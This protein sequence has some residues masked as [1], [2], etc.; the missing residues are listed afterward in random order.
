MNP[1]PFE[2]L[3]LTQ[4][5]R[6][7]FGRIRTLEQIKA[8]DPVVFEKLCGW[9]Y[10][11]EGYAVSMTPKTGDQGVDLLLEK[12]GER[13]VVQC[14]RYDGTVGQ[15]VVRDLFGTMMHEQGTGAVLITSGNFSQQA[16]DWG[17]EKPIRLIDGTG[18]HNWLKY[19]N[20]QQAK[21]ATKGSFLESY[22]LSRLGVAGVVLLSLGLCLASGF[23]FYRT[24]QTIF[25]PQTTA[26]STLPAS[27]VVAVKTK[28]AEL[29]ETA[30]I[31]VTQTPT[32]T[33]TPTPTITALAN[34]GTFTIAKGRYDFTAD[35][36]EWESVTPITSNEQIEKSEEWGGPA[37]LSAMWRLLYDENFLYGYVVVEDDDLTQENANPIYLYN[38]DSLELHIDSLKDRATTPQTDDFQYL[39]SPG[40]F[41][42]VKAAVF[43][44]EGDGQ[45]MIEAWGTKAEIA[46]FPTTKGYTISFRIPWY[47]L[48]L[49]RPGLGEEIGISL[50]VNDKDGDLPEQQFTNTT[51]HK[52]SQPATWGTMKLGE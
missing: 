21:T 52:W 39:L 38:G 7:Q 11:T 31:G 50:V 23:M 27:T 6:Q 13:I 20:Q 51:T 43:R 14:K 24:Y 16:L 2:R 45:K 8:L 15:P 4:K 26:K 28:S 3:Q 22:N 12:K 29:A 1:L 9:L 32:V 5:E 46:S 48:K 40:N 19:V 18:L 47:D 36:T 42:G 37:D 10:E 44:Y 30:T 33:I 41:D 17:H 25:T 34:Q 49:R 35:L